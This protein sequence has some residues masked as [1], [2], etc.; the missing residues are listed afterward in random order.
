MA[1]ISAVI[2]TYNEERNIARCLGSLAGI[3]DEIIVVDSFSTDKTEEICNRYKVSFVKHP[4]E[5][6]IQQKNYAL[7]LANYDFVLSLDADEALSDELRSVLLQEKINPKAQAYYFN[8]KTNYCGQWL[9]YCWYPDAKVRFW[10]KNIG[11][12]GGVNPHDI[13]ILK[14][15]ILPRKLQ[16][17]LLHYSYYTI[18]QHIIQLDKFTE[19][20][21]CELKHKGVD[22]SMW[23]LLLGPASKFFSSY[24][25]KLGILDG[26]NGFVVCKISAYATFVKYAK[27]RKLKNQK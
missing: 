15:G 5:G 10:N 21:A 25:L 12:W 20:A 8:R 16:G 7:G 14:S 13:V 4:F 2:I 1:N 22:A 23:K 9:N 11:L 26:L 3:A 18:S 27:L 24:F 17:D 19:I 6:H